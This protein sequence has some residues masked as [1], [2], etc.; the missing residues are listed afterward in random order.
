MV[1]GTQTAAVEAVAEQAPVK[2]EVRDLSIS[3]GNEAA[4][5][6]LMTPRKDFSLSV[7]GDAF[8]ACFAA[9]N[10]SSAW[11]IPQNEYTFTSYSLTAY[12]Y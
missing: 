10:A 4:L 5:H 7:Q 3:Y 11:L 9:E 1:A 6:N 8:Q 2:L 12:S